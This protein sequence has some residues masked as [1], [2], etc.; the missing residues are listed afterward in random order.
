MGQKSSYRTPVTPSK[1]ST[2]KAIKQT[3]KQTNDINQNKFL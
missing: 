3:I 2:S 1:I